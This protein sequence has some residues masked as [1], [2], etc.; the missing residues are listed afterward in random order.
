MLYWILRIS[1][2]TLLLVAVRKRVQTVAV[3]YCLV[4]RCALRCSGCSCSVDCN[5]TVHD[6]QIAEIGIELHAA[7]VAIVYCAAGVELDKVV[8]HVYCVRR[9]TCCNSSS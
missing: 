1:S 2:V 3:A 9:S 4:S 8:I 5:T 7:Y 6:T